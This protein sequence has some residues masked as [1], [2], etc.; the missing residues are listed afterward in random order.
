[1]YVVLLAVLMYPQIARA[2]T[3]VALAYFAG[4]VAEG[5]LLAG[6]VISQLL[7]FPL[8]EAHLQASP[9]EAAL[10]PSLAR[11]AVRA[12]FL[13]FQV[14]MLL[15]GLASLPLCLLFLRT[16]LLPAWLALWGLAG[17]TLLLAGAVGSQDV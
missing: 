4:R 9:A 5:L 12:N 17:Y 3:R 2:S 14:A 8:A 11:I 1:M 13:A 6:G 7:L 10:F 15:L 16:R